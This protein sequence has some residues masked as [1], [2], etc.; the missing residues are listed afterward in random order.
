[1]LLVR[2][3]GFG[4]TERQ[5]VYLA[6][7]LAARGNRVRV[8][9]FYPGGPFEAEF[10]AANPERL[11][12]GKRGRG[13][14]VGFCSRLR[15]VLSAGR[16]DIVYSFLPVPNLLA[17][18]L[19]S[20]SRRAPVVVWG[21]R[22]TPLE[23]A[24]YDWLERASI[25][26]E[27]TLSRLPDLLI[28]NSRSGAEWARA[29]HAGARRIEIVPNGIDTER[30]RPATSTERMAA[31]NVLGCPGR[32]VVVAVVGRLDPMKDHQ[33]FLRGLALAAGRAPNLVGLIAGGGAPGAVE[34]LKAIASALGIADRVIWTGARRDVAE[35]YHAADLLCLPSAFGEGF[36]NVV[37][38]AMASGLPC[39]VTAVGDN[40]ELIGST[41][42]VVPPRKPE[43]IAGALVDYAERIGETCAFDLAGRRRVVAHFSL[44]PMI[45][46]T[47]NL[48]RQALADRL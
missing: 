4:G 26:L 21:I 35:I 14:I 17:V 31:R 10:A 39:I 41:G 33:T 29:Y 9:S 40:A 24:H 48:L 1:M 3:L 6:R 27:R 25:R 28:A 47:E 45:S 43:A 11:V 38:E 15:H 36:P 22:G 32:A 20:M 23:L 13:D 12:I 44:E 8:A 34:R 42:L 2:A 30:F 7:G 5:V 18:A 16:P 19:A 46:K 37:G